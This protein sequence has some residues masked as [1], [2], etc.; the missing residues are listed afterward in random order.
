MIMSV[1]RVLVA[2]GLACLAGAVVK[3]GFASPNVVTVCA[4][5][6]GNVKDVVSPGASRP[7][8]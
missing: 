7:P 2:F 5:D 3:L 8:G 4:C 6:S 1:L